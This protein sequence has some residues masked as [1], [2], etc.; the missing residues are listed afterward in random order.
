MSYTFGQTK[1]KVVDF[2]LYSVGKNY[3][4]ERLYYVPKHFAIQCNAKFYFL[5]YG[6]DDYGRNCKI[7]VGK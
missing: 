2:E 7:F 5:G 6:I 3:K 4:G 1:K